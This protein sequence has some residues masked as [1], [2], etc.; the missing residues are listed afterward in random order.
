M[1]NLS[2]LAN[3]VVQTTPV[4]VIEAFA[5]VNA[6]A[7]W[8]FC[9]G[10][11]I[12]RIQYPELFSALSTTYGSGDGSTTFNIPDMRGRIPVGKGTHTDVA[13][14]GNNEGASLANRRPKHQHTVYFS[15][16]GHQHAGD[17][18][19]AGV[20]GSN[21]SNPALANT[22]TSY[23]ATRSATTGINIKVNPEG[24]SS[25]T[26]P[27][28]SPPYLVTNYI[29][30]AVA[31][32]PRGGW[33]YQNQPPVVTQLPSNPQIGEQVYHLISGKYI[34]KRYNGSSWDEFS[35]NTSSLPAGSVVQVGR[36]GWTNETSVNGSGAGW[37]SATNSSYTFT[38]QFSNS[39]ILIQFEWAMAPYHPGQTYA[40]M[41]CRGLWGGSVVTVQGQTH[42]VYVATGSNADLYSRTVKSISFTANTTNPTAI[43]TQIAV[44]LATTNGRLNQSANWASY[45]TVWEIKG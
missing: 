25:S 42:E 43:T 4:G 39:T 13:T 15:D 35:I 36:Y 18:N 40:G 22:G 27:T 44:Y 16:P 17:Y 34:Q 26:S 12:S 19:V 2:A 33:F 30:K 31:D 5:G 37:V 32:L 10:S 28:D 3:N 41:S 24:A 20:A 8:L 11:A 14:L 6:P 21:Q 38:P 9:D 45:Y 29:I 7:G 23:T 1:G